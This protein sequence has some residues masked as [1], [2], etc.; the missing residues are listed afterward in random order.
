MFYLSLS[1]LTS[2][3]L[4]D[5]DRISKSTVLACEVL[6]IACGVCWDEARWTAMILLPL[7]LLM[8]TF[9]SISCIPTVYRK[10]GQLWF[11]CSLTV[12]RVPCLSIWKAD[13]PEHSSWYVSL[14]NDSVDLWWWCYN[15]CFYQCALFAVMCQLFGFVI[16]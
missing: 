14:K 11:P 7:L 16:L 10:H 9:A 4:P 6:F 5:S 15:R 1:T 2:S 12:S 3:N 13:L 8:V